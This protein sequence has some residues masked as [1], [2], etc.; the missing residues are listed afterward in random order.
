MPCSYWLDG[1]RA[2]LDALRVDQPCARLV[3]SHA[4]ADR[5]APACAWIGT[6]PE[7]GLLHAASIA[8]GWLTMRALVQG[9]LPRTR[10]R[11][12]TR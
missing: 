12:G 2:V 8:P 9:T 4:P 7:V 3:L 11:T 5:I 10:G 1:Q 6:A